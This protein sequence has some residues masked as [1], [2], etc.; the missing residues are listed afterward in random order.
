MSDP[1]KPPKDSRP[2]H[3][4]DCS[5][6]HRITSIEKQMGRLQARVYTVERQGKLMAEDIA[7]QL[8]QLNQWAQASVDRNIDRILV[9][10]AEM[11]QGVE[12]LRRDV[13]DIQCL[14]KNGNAKN[15]NA[16][17]E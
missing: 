15:G 7:G 1:D 12:D 2:I 13:R 10:T 11:A 8:K 9:R 6:N 5:Q 16:R 4:E 14:M 17:S 3:G